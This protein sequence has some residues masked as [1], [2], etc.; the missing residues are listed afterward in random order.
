[1]KVLILH[2]HV[3]ADAPPDQRDALAQVDAVAA[4][5]RHHAHEATAHPC[6]LDLGGLERTLREVAP[7]V[8][9][10]LVESLGGHGRL[11]GTVPLLLESLGIPFTGN[12]SAPT[13]LT[14]NKVI[15]KRLMRGSNLPTP[16]WIETDPSRRAVPTHAVGGGPWP[17]GETT[18]IVKSVWE[19]ASI[20]LDED[21][22]VAV[23]T[24][25]DLEQHIAQRLPALRGE[26]FAERFIDGREFNI[27][28][29][30]EEPPSRAGGAGPGVVA[31]PEILPIAE[32]VF[33]GY[34][35]DKPRVIGYRAKWDE[36]S[37]EYR[38]TVRR[39]DF[40]REDEGLLERLRGVA[41]RAWEVF[42]L[43]GYARV[44]VRVDGR[45]EPWI[46]EVN[47]NPCIAP[48]AGFAAALARAEIPYEEAIERLVLAALARGGRAAERP[49]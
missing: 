14:A 37:D 9:F 21:S 15:A 20:G 49:G 41:R 44:D 32:M 36:Q 46:L 8:V 17:R 48:D 18:W 10:N 23:R 12:G 24:R 40:G 13:L 2:D 11:V 22:V 34:G 28:L 6:T 42:G 31:V 43:A 33:E 30:E 39:F 7:D 45:H 4:A 29:I 5:L 38:R 16:E 35:A 47:T 26:G 19:H 27:A 1:M 3:P 25:L